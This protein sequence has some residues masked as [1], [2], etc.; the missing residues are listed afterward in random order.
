MCIRTV[1][2]KPEQK[3][4]KYFP[5]P[6][7]ML[8][9][10]TSESSTAKLT[11]SG[12]QKNKWGTQTD[13]AGGPHC[14]RESRTADSWRKDT[15]IRI[16]AG[17]RTR[18]RKIANAHDYVPSHRSR[19]SLYTPSCRTTQRLIRTCLGVHIRAAIAFSVTAQVASCS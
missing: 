10:G 5:N 1:N 14:D 8:A 17:G 19:N 15:A 13:L 11:A 2:Y 6:S 12:T 16:L 4:V 3:V 7:D 18:I 9:Q